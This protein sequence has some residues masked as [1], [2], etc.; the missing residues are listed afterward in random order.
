MYAPDFEYII[1]DEADGVDCWKPK[2]MR[3]NQRSSASSRASRSLSAG[4]LHHNSL[5]DWGPCDVYCSRRWIAVLA[6][7][8]GAWA[9]RLVGV[10]EIPAQVR[11]CPLWIVW[12]YPV[13]HAQQ[14]QDSS[15]SRDLSH[16]CKALPA[17]LNGSGSIGYH[18][19]LRT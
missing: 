12:N 15:R 16:P 9:D 3:V 7:G 19:D 10:C 5:V 2:A 1:V 8:H 13:S 4:A 14:Q 17:G 18:L 6:G 11:S